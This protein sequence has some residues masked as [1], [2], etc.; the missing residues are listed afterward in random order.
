MIRLR[1]HRTRLLGASVL[2]LALAT[3][4][5]AQPA[6]PGLDGAGMDRSVAPGDDFYRYASG[7]WLQQ[8]EIPADRSAFGSFNVAAQQAEAQLTALVR[9]AAASD[10]P[11][12]SD[13]RKIGD[14]Y[15][16][17]LD[18]TA[19]AAA[20]LA[21]LRPVLARIGAIG[22]RTAL[23]RYVGA[24]L[25]AD[26]D[27]INDGALHTANLFG[28]WVDQ[29]F[30]QPTRNS[31]ALLQG[32]LA[33]PDRSYYLDPSPAMEEVRE[34][35]RA[36]VA[37]M[38]ALAGV[39]D[40]DAKA[41]AVLR[42]ETRIAQ[43]HWNREDTWDVWK[44]NNHWSKADFATQAPG[45]DW[46]AFF[47]AAGLAEIDTLVAWQPSAITG[48]SALAASEPL[49]DWKALLAYHAIEHRAAVLPSAFGDEAFAFFG[50]TLSG[51]PEQRPRE[52]RAVAATSDAL[53][54]AVGR[55]YVER[56]FPASAKAQTEDDGGPHH[57]GIRATD[58]RAGLDGAGDEGRS[59]GQA[60]NPA[61]QRGLPRRVAHLRRTRR[62]AR[63]TPSATPSGW[64]ASSTD[65][66]ST[67]CAARSTGRSGR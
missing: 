53:G 39:P 60:P 8:T 54:F 29:D 24:T 20:G 44:G 46:D 10:A 2:A 32:G 33:M 52:A 50:Q 1:H 18:T 27:V 38:L 55:Q 42:L 25:R 5:A 28:L 19:I 40:A 31:A 7:A 11:E 36:H 4:L 17:Y 61:R 59:E 56:Y 21:P 22:D 12:G 64:S 67:S 13:L 6:I 58:R 47:A 63:P 66:P 15:T 57:R 41:D 26:V 23:A 16:A 45:L 35:Y 30:D 37:R 34:Q 49:D 14:F 43:A 51:A 3:P 65:G 48:L 62:V 9:E